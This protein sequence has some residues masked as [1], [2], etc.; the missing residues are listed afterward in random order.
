MFP[1]A[2]EFRWDAGH[3]IFFGLFYTVVFIIL[4]SLCY[5]IV[6]SLVDAYKVM[7]EGQEQPHAMESHRAAA[8]TSGPEPAPAPALGGAHALATHPQ[9]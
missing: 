3:M 9:S 2:F 8:Q 4:T 6:K 7:R 5:V 1:T